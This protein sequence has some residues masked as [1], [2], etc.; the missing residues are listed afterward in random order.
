MSPPRSRFVFVAGLHRTG[1]SLLARIIAAHPAI[2]DLAAGEVAD[3][4][5]HRVRGGG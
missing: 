4:A 2:S 1:T 5:C 3:S